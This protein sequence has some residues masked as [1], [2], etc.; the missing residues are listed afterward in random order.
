MSNKQVGEVEA[1]PGVYNNKNFHVFCMKEP[2]YTMM[3]MST[4]ASLQEIEGSIAKRVWEA[5]KQ[6]SFLELTKDRDKPK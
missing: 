5:N 2:A 4:Y 6:Y 1:L 3:L